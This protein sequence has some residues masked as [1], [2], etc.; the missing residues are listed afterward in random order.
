M[1]SEE[2]H[3]AR[4]KR[5]KAKRLR[6]VAERSKQYTQDVFTPEAIANAYK[7]HKKNTG[8]KTSVQRYGSNLTAN[9]VKASKEV[10]SGRWKSKVFTNLT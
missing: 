5:R 7:L 4:Y 8:K 1:T 2:R 10:L 6:K 9:V 3:E